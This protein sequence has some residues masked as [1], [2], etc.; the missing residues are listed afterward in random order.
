MMGWRGRVGILVPPGNPTLEPELGLL[1]PPGC[2]FHFTRM[3]ASGVTGSLQGQEERNREQI[4]SLVAATALLAAVNPGVVALAHT[5]TSYTLGR[6]GEAALVARM[7]AAHPFRFTTA[8]AAILAA[9]QVLGIRRVAFG[10]PY[11][12]DTTAAGAALLR[13][14]GIE[15]ASVCSLPGV[16]NIYDETAERAYRLGR[17]ADRRDADAIV[18]SGVGMP[19]LSTMARLERDTGKPV[20]SATS[21]LAWH[22]TRLIGCREPIAGYGR[23][24]GTA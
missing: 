12:A 5:S 24:L 22:V 7:E 2:S 6:A 21:A 20:L 16:R 18:L 10:A 17:M 3:A 9:L 13:E 23:L 19:T 14:H 15:V 11:A 8:F 4:E 1:M